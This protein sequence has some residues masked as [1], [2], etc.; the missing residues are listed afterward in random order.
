MA[1][2]IRGSIEHYFL[3]TGLGTGSCQSFFVNVYN[4][5]NNNSASLGI[6]RISYN[7]GSQATGMEKFRGMNYFDSPNPCGENSW[8]VFRF[9]SASI[10]FDV[11]IQHAAAT[12]CNSAPAIPCLMNATNTT[13]HFMASVAHSGSGD[14]TWNGTLKNDGNDVKGSPV[15]KNAAN[16]FYTPRSNDS[17]RAGAQGTLKQN[18]MGMNVTTNGTYRQHIIADYDSFVILLDLAADNSYYAMGYNS[19]TPTT[20]LTATVP[21]FGFC[22]TAL[23]IV[24][25]TGFGSVD[26]TANTNGG[27]AH[28]SLG[29][30]GSCSCGFDRIGTTFFKSANAQ[31]NKAWPIQHFDEFPL[32][33]GIFET[34]HIGLC[35][36]HSYFLREAYNIATH[37][38][39]ADGSRAAFGSTTLADIKLTVPWHSGT[40]PGTGISRTGV[41]FGT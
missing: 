3:G 6:Q 7:T 18:M 19:Y 15:W 8:A 4:F 11:L 20:G 24:E 40:V 12:A 29:V 35:G 17:T 14:S 23:P 13:Y 1:G 38:T 26:G 25:G 10:P 28:P 22:T 39:N 37:D 16:T 5:F 33:V 36:Q 34:P 30:S 32:F 2:P 9:M 41:Q 31:A 21:Y 27:C